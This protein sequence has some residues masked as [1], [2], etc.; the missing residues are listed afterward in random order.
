MEYID[1][2]NEKDEVVGRA[3]KDEIYE[4]LLPHRIVHILIF[5]KKGELA[6][7]L[8]SAK[9]SF[10]PLHWSTAVGGHVQAGEAY[11][12]GAQRECREEIGVSVPMKFFAKDWYFDEVRELK[13]LLCTFTAIF[14]GEIKIEPE[15][16]ERIDY[17]PLARV[18]EMMEKGEKFHPE[19]LFLLN[20]HSKQL[21]KLI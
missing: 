13:K 17:F 14:D 15:E 1:I 3:S 8:R 2:I 10:C 6:L 21:T 12:Q 11:E 9:K 16:V 18:Y 20:K 5:N 19:L 4:K 7:Q